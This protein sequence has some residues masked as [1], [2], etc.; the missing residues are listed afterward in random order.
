MRKENEDLHHDRFHV[1]ATKVR[2][3]RLIEHVDDLG[4]HEIVS[5]PEQWPIVSVNGGLIQVDGSSPS[6][7]LELV[8]HP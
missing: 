6:G 2:D 3:L 4:L 8:Q 5:V 7:T 1:K